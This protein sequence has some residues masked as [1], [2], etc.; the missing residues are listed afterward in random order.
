[1]A[2]LD[3]QVFRI[4]QLAVDPL[5]LDHGGGIVLNVG[6][7]VRQALM[8]DFQGRFQ[9]MLAGLGLGLVGRLVGHAVNRLG[10]RIAIRA[11]SLDRGLRPHVA[12]D[13][14]QHHEAD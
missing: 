7:D 2:D 10:Q 5:T 14:D 8:G 6:L 9:R 4:G 11:S 12:H 3:E 13:S 1:M